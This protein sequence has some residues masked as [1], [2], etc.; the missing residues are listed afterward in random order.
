M[1]LPSIPKIPKMPK[2]SAEELREKLPF[3]PRR[4]FVMSDSEH[5]EN[6]AGMDYRPSTGYIPPQHRLCASPG[7]APAAAQT[8]VLSKH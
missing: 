8:P 1:K 4:E 2:L 3:Q 5:P 7:P 6:G